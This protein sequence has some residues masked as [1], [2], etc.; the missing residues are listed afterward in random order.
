MMQDTASQLSSPVESRP[1]RSALH[2]Y[3]SSQNPGTC[4]FFPKRAE[5]ITHYA[6]ADRAYLLPTGPVCMSA[7][8]HD[9]VMQSFPVKMRGW[10]P[11]LPML[12]HCWKLA[13]LGDFGFLDLKTK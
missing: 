4:S 13:L 1:H 12:R 10:Q 3:A 5:V 6:A 2:Q 7:A 9:R 11:T 8:R